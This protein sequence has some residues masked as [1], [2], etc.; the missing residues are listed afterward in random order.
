MSQKYFSMIVAGLALF[1]AAGCA[2]GKQQIAQNRIAE[3]EQQLAEK[4]KQLEMANTMS[5][6]ADIVFDDKVMSR[7]SR[8]SSSSEAVSTVKK[9]DKNIQ[10]ALKNAG[11][12]KGSIDGKIGKKTKAAIREFQRSKGLKAD[13]VV[14]K[15]TWRKMQEYL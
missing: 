4:D 10:R 8:S 5:K 14:G 11:F 2:T 13:G 7:S 9:T 15:R 1:A 12:Y 3:L 6:D